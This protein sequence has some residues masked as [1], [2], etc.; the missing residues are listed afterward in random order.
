[1]PQRIFWA[2]M[3]GLIAMALLVGGGKAALGALQSG[4]VT[5]GLPFMLVLLLMAVSLTLGLR[6]EG[7]LLRA[8]PLPK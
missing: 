4:A 3:E 7:K 5:T 1:M 2:I 8:N 6:S